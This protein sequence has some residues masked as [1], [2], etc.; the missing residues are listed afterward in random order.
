MTLF[1]TLAS[2][3]TLVVVG[4]LIAPLIRRETSSDIE[5]AAANVAI[6]RHRRTELDQDTAAGLVA[7]EDRTDMESELEQSLAGDLSAL[8]SKQKTEAAASPGRSRLGVP[9][10][11]G[12]AITLGAIPVLAAVLYVN[13]GQP[14][15]V[16]RSDRGD[17]LA[18]QGEGSAPTMQEMLASLEERVSTHPD[19]QRARVLLGRTYMSMGRYQDAVEVFREL[20]KDLNN[21]PDVKLFYAD[22]LAMTA[23]GDLRGRPAELVQTALE[24]NPSHPKALWLAAIVAEQQGNSDQ[25]LARLERL[26]PLLESGSEDAQQVQ[27]LIGQIRGEGTPGQQAVQQAVPGPGASSSASGS[28][29][30]EAPAAE[31]GAAAGPGAELRVRVALDASLRDAVNGDDVVFV[32]AKAPDGRPMPLAAARLM[33]SDLPAQVTLTDAMAMIPSMRLSDFEQVKLSARVALGG[34]AQAQSGDLVSP[35]QQVETS[36][37]EPVELAI[38]ESMP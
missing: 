25:A 15:L 20:N 12:S 19:D 31:S 36:R 9:N 34:K 3:L 24:L 38:N 35:T 23:G 32:V 33:V 29:A 18:Q 1:V 10:W 4:V 8:E 17:F 30:M 14:N 2:V 16:D 5:N 6:A 28:A 37:I 7:N 27:Q 11:V 26:K 21:N 22:A 13:L